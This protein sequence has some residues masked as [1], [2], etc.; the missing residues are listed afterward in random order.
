MKTVQGLQP[1]SSMNHSDIAQHLVF[2][3]VLSHSSKTLTFQALALSKKAGARCTWVCMETIGQNPLQGSSKQTTAWWQITSKMSMEGWWMVHVTVL[4]VS[5]VFLTCTDQQWIRCKLMQVCLLTDSG[6]CKQHAGKGCGD[7]ILP[8][9][10]TIYRKLS[11]A[12]QAA[13]SPNLRDSAITTNDATFVD[14][15]E[16]SGNGAKSVI[17]QKQVSRSRVQQDCR[18]QHR[19]RNAT[20]L[21]VRMT[22][23]AAR[24]SSPASTKTFCISALI[25]GHQMNFGAVKL[26][27]SGIWYNN[28]RLEIV[29]THRLNAQT[30]CPD[31][32]MPCILK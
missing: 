29:A 11:R 32:W 16:V 12:I 19:P 15:H 20:W 23:A 27:W 13:T 31:V 3:Q 4:P 14:L 25:E 18:L 10:A 6:H 7:T 17:I 22:M 28:K 21:T 9:A 2:L 5:T 8:S 30:I 26:V 1:A 24:A